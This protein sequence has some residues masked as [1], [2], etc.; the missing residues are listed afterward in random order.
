M[1]EERTIIAGRITDTYGNE[2]ACIIKLLDISSKDI[3][4]PEL[5][6]FNID[7]GLVPFFIE[8]TET[9]GN[10][11]IIVK[12]E[13]IED[14]DRAKRFI[15]TDILMRKSDL[16][17]VDTDPNME[18]IGF[19][20][21]DKTSGWEGTLDRVIDTPGN[22]LFVA[23]NDENDE[24]FIPAHDDLIKK[25]NYKKRVIKMTLPDGLIEISTE[26]I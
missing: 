15:G 7:N 26:D 14:N 23:S 20:I 3:K 6:F 13:D 4:E 5:V 22:K 9:Q 19:K 12:L 2:G 18:L 8:W 21:I 17:E 1:Q 11:K 16:A 25:I 10:K 24:V